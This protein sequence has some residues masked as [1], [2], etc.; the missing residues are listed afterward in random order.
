[1]VS[2][3]C[4]FYKRKFTN[5]IIQF[6][7]WWKSLVNPIQA[8]QYFCVSFTFQNVDIFTLKSQVFWDV[9]LYCWAGSSQH[10][11]GSWWLHPE[12]LVYK[13]EGAVI[14]QFLGNNSFNWTASPPR[15][16]QFSATP[17]WDP[18]ISYFTLMLLWVHNCL[19]LSISWILWD[20]RFS[21]QCFRRLRCCGMWLHVAGF[22][23]LDVSNN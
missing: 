17:P 22:V 3:Y 5:F 20:L 6:F 10:F 16:L 12:L 13:D 7:L 8:T 11:K 9:T 21:Q 23:V 4:V 19:C 1:M 15:L 2:F 18:Q 14:L